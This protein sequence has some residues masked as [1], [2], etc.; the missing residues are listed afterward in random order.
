MTSSKT[1]FRQPLEHHRDKKFLLGLLLL[2]FL[3]CLITVAVYFLTDQI[4]QRE[5]QKIFYQTG[6]RI[7]Q[8]VE[9]RML[10]HVNTLRGL[11][12]F[13]A[14]SGQAVTKEKFDAYLETLNIFH[15][16]PGISSISFFKPRGD[17][18]ITEYLYPL[19]GREAALGLD[20][21]FDPDRR[22]FFEQTRDSGRISASRPFTLKTTQ[23]P[24]VFL[25]APL[26]AGGRAPESL[27]ERRGQL[28]GFV[29]MVFREKELF[30]A[31]FGRSN[32]FPDI[33]FAIYHDY[34]EALP[35]DGQSEHLLFDSDPEFDPAGFSQLLQTKKYVTVGGTQWTIFITAKPSFSL[36]QT[37]EN[38]PLAILITGLTASVAFG[39]IGLYFVNK[40]LKTWHQQDKLAV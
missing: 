21:Y 34:Y 35:Q 3:G 29:G 40:H 37:E 22:A 36:T 18:L 19:E 33:D 14:G 38:L 28:I 23:R 31:I 2:N 5:R 6:G 20:Q 7:E 39:I 26:Y 24:G 8:L 17:K 15:D 1:S 11:R 32:P 9:E 16:Y 25:A 4:L 12:A 30:S 27:I 13:W 10:S